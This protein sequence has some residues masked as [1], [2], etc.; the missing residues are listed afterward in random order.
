MKKNYFSILL[1]IMFLPSHFF[2]QT[3]YYI[4]DPESLKEVIYKAGDVII[5]KN[6]VYDTDERMIFLGSGTAEN[7]VTFRAETPGGVIFTGGPRL[8]IGGESDGNDLATGEYL[9]VDGFHWKGGYGASNFIEFRNGDD[10]AHHSTI[11]NCVIDGLG[12][13]QSELDEDLADEQITKHRWIVLYGTYNTVI[14]CA[15]MNKVTAGAIVLGEYSYNAFPNVPDGTP[16][17]NNSCEIVGHTI[18]NNYFYNFEKLTEKYGRKANGDELS[19]AGDSE[20]IRIGTSSYQ[21]VNSNV[22]V[23]NNYFVQSDGENEIITNKSKGNT[24]T[25]NT[26]RRCR[27]S[28]VLRHG[29]KAKIEGNYFL[30]EDVDGTGGIRISDSDHVITNNYIQDCITVDNFAKW[31]NGITFIGGSANAD[32]DCTT[33]DVSNGYQ[34]TEDITV[35]NN[36]IINTNAPLFYNVNTD[37]NSDVKGNIENNLIY[38]EANDPNLS[39]VISGDETTSY[40][41]IGASLTYSGNVFSGTTLGETNTGFSE[42]TGITATKDGEIFTFSG[43]G[44]TGKGANMGSYTPITDAMVGYG[45]G[46]C[47]LDYEGANITDGNCTIKVS[48]SL[49]VSSLSTL[50]PEAASYDVTVTANVSWTAASNDSWL[51]ID[52]NSGTGNATVSITVTENTDTNSR[53]GSIT[54]TQDAGGDDIVRTLTLSQDGA[55]LIDLYNLINTGTGL[56]TDKVTVHSLSKENTSKSE[57]AINSLDKNIDTEWTADDEDVLSGD[58]KADGEYIIYDLSSIH[59]VGLIQF[60]TTNKSDA[61]GFQILTSTTGTEDADFTMILPTSGELLLT[62]TNTTEFNQYEINTD[63]RYIKVIGYGRFNSDGDTRKSAWSAI[64]EIEF[65]EKKNALSINENEI[66]NVLI[67]PNPANNTLFI[68][69][70]ENQISKVEIISLEGKIVTSLAQN[71]NNELKIDTSHLANGM[72]FIKLSND[73]KESKTKLIVI[74]H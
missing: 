5:L 52:T 63:A 73:K 54:F 26:F 33:D 10:Y 68:K 42:E 20:T 48:E 36:T 12:V 67:Y 46:A 49:T 62:A 1:C 30:G 41:S 2:G 15:F 23:S 4:D 53:S 44:S 56:S 31:N 21:M 28:L 55:N 57:L 40:A 43:E 3:T 64:K 60:R 45:I 14:N 37:N 74:N 39:P 69:D 47:F 17:V 8:T 22:V 70:L 6:G 18:M 25:N 32:V 72:Y 50:A 19:N 16:E 27:G 11:Q 66:L 13:E 24:Y 29:S 7:P 65:Y 34:K 35:S 59:S 71:N 51:T 61:F 9:V 58:Y 38:F